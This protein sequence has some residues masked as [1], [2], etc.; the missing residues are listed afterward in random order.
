VLE[1]A[2]GRQVL[3]MLRICPQPL[4]VVLDQFMPALSGEESCIPL[5]KTGVSHAA[6]PSYW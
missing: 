2:D 3:E 5:P 1:A 4:V 6:M